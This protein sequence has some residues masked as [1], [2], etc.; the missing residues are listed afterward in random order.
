MRIIIKSV[1]AIGC[2]SLCVLLGSC[3]GITE[4]GKQEAGDWIESR[5]ETDNATESRNGHGEEALDSERQSEGQTLS[6]EEGGG[7]ESP[8]GEEGRTGG[9]G[10]SEG[11][12]FREGKQDWAEEGSFGVT[13]QQGEKTEA[14]SAKELEEQ[15]EEIPLPKTYDLRK[16]GRVPAIKNQGE[17]GTCW[18]F[19]SLTA[20]ESSLLPED[21][22]DF[23]EDNMSL[24]HNFL[25]G[26]EDGGDYTMSMAYLVSW[27]GPVLEEKDPYGDKKTPSGLTAVRHVQEIQILPEKDFDCIKQAILDIGGVQSSL[28]TSMK[29]PGSESEYYNKETAA[30]YYDGKESPNH[31]SVIIGWDDTYP[32]ENF[33][34]PPPGDGAFLCMNSWG[35]GFGKDGCFYVSYYDTNIG[36]HNIVYTVTELPD[37]YDRIYQSDLCGWIGQLG[38]GQDTAWFANVYE[39]KEEE[40]LKAVGFYAT[41]PNTSYEI[42]TAVDVK[43]P[44]NSAEKN[45]E[46]GTE[47][48]TGRK[49]M[50]SG[51]VKA[52]EG[53]MDYAG[54][55]TIPLDKKVD[56]KKGERFAVIV[57]IKTPGAVHPVA[58][59]YDAQDGKCSIDL[60]DGE[61]YI[62]VQ[63]DLWDSAEEK[64]ECNIC[65]KAYT[66][67]KK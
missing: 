52:G 65:L 53:K 25:L 39:A 14:Q 13:P 6:G 41:G 24:N 10:Q 29:N 16:T 38:Y 30:Y 47:K 5:Q 18:A 21:N 40:M 56:L 61:G 59:E 15:K 50:F 64:Q 31:D 46:E 2:L 60:N 54:Y 36:V 27:Q 63:G 62:S 7:G 37:N 33:S 19:A 45:M 26:Q 42:Y 8:P 49:D 34:S 58:I 57:R 12:Y 3:K 17:L 4:D 43:A 35:T 48:K 22:Y 44:G 11:A 1:L 32:K 66:E 55:Y 51:M 67:E 20:L 23:S 9:K 28:Y